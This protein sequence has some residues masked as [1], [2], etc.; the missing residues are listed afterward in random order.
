MMAW[1][2]AVGRYLVTGAAGFIGSKVTDILLA[3]GNE[4]V[5]LDNL[6]DAYDVRLKEWRLRQLEG[7]PGFS[8]VRVDICD[9]RALDAL[10]S[11]TSRVGRLPG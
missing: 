4:V 8:F 3:E 9:V 11:T 2:N 7:H 5:G 1:A 6:N 10:M